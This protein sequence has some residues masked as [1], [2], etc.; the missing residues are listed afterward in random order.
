MLA[1]LCDRFCDNISSRTLSLKIRDNLLSHVKL[2]VFLKMVSY[3][4]YCRSA[5][6]RETSIFAS[7]RK[8][9]APN[10]VN[11]IRRCRSRLYR[12]NPLTCPSRA[13]NNPNYH[14]I[15]IT[16][17]FNFFCFFSDR[18]RVYGEVC[19]A[20]KSCCVSTARGGAAWNRYILHSMVLR[21]RSDEHQVHQRHF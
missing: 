10:P 17:L 18:A 12:A 15:I 16:Y 6:V 3:R 20:D 7:I 5:C 19:F 13:F 8:T 9:R 14:F 2:H 4:R 21:L 1:R 11:R